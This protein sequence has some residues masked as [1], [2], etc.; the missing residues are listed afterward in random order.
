MRWSLL[1]LVPAVVARD[2]AVLTTF[3]CHRLPSVMRRAPAAL[4]VMGEP[5]LG[6]HAHRPRHP[7]MEVRSCL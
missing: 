5:V 7:Y 4:R 6:P 3:R 1:T 2:G